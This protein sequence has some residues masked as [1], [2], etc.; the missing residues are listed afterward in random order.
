MGSEKKKTHVQDDLVLEKLIVPF[1]IN[2]NYTGP[3][4][5]LKHLDSSATSAHESCSRPNT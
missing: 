4:K 3:T 1:E 5:L 2:P